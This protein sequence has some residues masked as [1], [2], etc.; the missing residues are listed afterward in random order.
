MYKARAI[1]EATVDQ[2]R[3]VIS[4]AIFTNMQCVHMDAK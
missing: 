4:I 1:G 2:Y 3:Y